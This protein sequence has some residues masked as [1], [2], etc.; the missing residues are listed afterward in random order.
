MR[1][2][3]IAFVIPDGVNVYGGFY[4]NE[5]NLDQRNSQKHQTVLSGAIGTADSSDNSLTVIYFKNASSATLLD[6]FTIEAGCANQDGKF[7]ELQKCGGG[8]YNDG[9]GTGNQSMPLIQK[10]HLPK[11]LCTRRGSHL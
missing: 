1:I 11:Q 2:E 6:G 10:L 8:L 7:G 9:I 5:T 4:G 3:T